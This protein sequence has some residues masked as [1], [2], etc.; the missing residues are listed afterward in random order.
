MPGL[1]I[2]PLPPAAP[3]TPIRR[4]EPRDGTPPPPR[5]QPRDERRREDADDK[6]TGI[7]TYA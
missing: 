6:S 5:R 3:A 2:K 7:D 4:V 1:D